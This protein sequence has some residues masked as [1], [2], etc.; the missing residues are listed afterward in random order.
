[1][2]PANLY[3][4]KAQ[5][6]LFLGG[7]ALAV[8][9]LFYADIA[10]GSVPIPISMVWKLLS[11]GT[12]SA[13]WTQIIFEFR[14]PKAIAAI[15]IGGGLALAGL[16]MQ[17]LFRNPLAGPDVLGI[18]SGASLGVALFVLGGSALPFMSASGGGIVLSAV[19][20]ASVLMFI[21][22]SVSRFLNSQVSLLIVGIMFGSLS[23]SLVSITQYF[24]SA[25]NIQRFVIWTFG[26]LGGITWDQLIWLVPIVFTGIISSILLIKPLN[27]LLLGE[28]YAMALGVP[29]RRLRY[30]IILLCSLIAGTITAF[31]GPIAF[32]GIAV[33]HIARNI[34]RSSDHIYIVPGSILSGMALMLLCDIVSQMPGNGTVLPINA[35]TAL[36]GAPLV[37]W[38]VLRK[39]DKGDTR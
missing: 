8:L 28:Q 12:A 24:S 9:V 25:E 31:A 34:F 1:M 38:V 4:G 7:L 33:P 16:L 22:L 13:G 6:P 11:G 5:G 21:S 36:F 30:V 35:V 2:K 27:A 23:G 32:V 20:G 14:M 19:A 29:V 10:C 18:N 37:I 3:F 39:T 26:S 17:T 15:A